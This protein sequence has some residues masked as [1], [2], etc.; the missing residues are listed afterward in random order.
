MTFS[1]S[2]P[3][4]EDSRISCE[5]RVE[6]RPERLFCLSSFRCAACDLQSGKED[7]DGDDAVLPLLFAALFL[8]NSSHCL[9]FALPTHSKP[10][11]PPPPP[12]IGNLPQTSDEVSVR[13]KDLHQHLLQHCLHDSLLRQ[14]VLADEPMNQLYSVSQCDS[15]SHICRSDTTK[16]DSSSLGWFETFVIG[17]QLR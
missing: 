14:A 2:S 8:T 4:T 3:E 1:H 9:Y 15:S 7:K 16:M 17:Q 13:S 11:G 5:S 10:P 12:L 6:S